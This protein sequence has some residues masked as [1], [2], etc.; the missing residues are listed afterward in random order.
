[1]K[2]FGSVWTNVKELAKGET[3][4]RSWGFGILLLQYLQY[5]G[6]TAVSFQ[7]SRIGNDPGAAKLLKRLGRDKSL[8]KCIDVLPVEFDPEF[9]LAEKWF[10]VC[11]TG[12]S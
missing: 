10:V 3:V 9:L 4:S 6:F 12:L 2:P 7:F 5:N 11:H 8:R 1:M